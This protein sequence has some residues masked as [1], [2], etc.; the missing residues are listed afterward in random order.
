VTAGVFCR[1]GLRVVIP[2]AVAA[3]AVLVA[4]A[5]LLGCG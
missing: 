1:M 4:F 3:L 5:P 2:A